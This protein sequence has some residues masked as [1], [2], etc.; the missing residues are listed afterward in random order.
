MLQEVLASSATYKLPQPVV[1]VLIY[2]YL[3]TMKLLFKSMCNYCTFNSQYKNINNARYPSDVL[4][5][6]HTVE[7]SNLLTKVPNYLQEYSYFNYAPVQQV[8]YLFIY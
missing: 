8:N 4:I 5:Q 6:L 1:S 7:M 2:F 3:E